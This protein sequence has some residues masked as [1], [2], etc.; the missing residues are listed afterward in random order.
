[1]LRLIT[2]F[3]GPIMDVSERY[4]RVYQLC[5]EQ[6]QRPDQ[7][8]RVLPKQEFWNM[9]RSRV[10]ETQIGILSGLDETQAA[11]FAQN[12]R[13]TVHTMPYLVYDQPVPG[14][15]E[16]LERIQQAGIDL[17]VMTMRRVRELDEAFT[18]CDLGRFFPPEKR[19][20]L[21][22]DY[23]KTGDT[24]DK[25]L[26]MA[27]ALAELSPADDV[28]MVGDT[29]ADIIAAKTHGV[30]VMGA[31]CGI[32]DRAQLELHQPDLIVNNLAAAVDLLL[33]VNS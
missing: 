8:I 4:Y 19:Y 20:C 16:T 9:K 25:P 30:K 13:K 3:D 6:A 1:M 22:N 5:L 24:K 29:E 10:P 33:T 23:V 2:D 7:E 32:R 26:L 12:R 14:A 18:R 15:V 31:L 11:E 17:V 27:R 21:P 28:W